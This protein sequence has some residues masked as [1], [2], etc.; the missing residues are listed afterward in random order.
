MRPLWRPCDE[1]WM[2]KGVLMFDAGQAARMRAALILNPARH[3]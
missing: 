1:E 2:A 3:N